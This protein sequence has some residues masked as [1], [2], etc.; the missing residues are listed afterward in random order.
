MNRILKTL[1]LAALVSFPAAAGPAAYDVTLTSVTPTPALM[2][3]PSGDGLLCPVTISVTNG[4]SRKIKTWWSYDGG[5]HRTNVTL[6]PGENVI[7]GG[8]PEIMAGTDAVIT[9][10]TGASATVAI[11]EPEKM[12]IYLVQHVHT[13]IGYTK[14]QT[15]ILTEHLR[16]ID[17]ALDYCDATASYPD[18]ARFRWTC[19]AS[20]AVD[21]WLRGRPKEQVERFLDYI[22]QGLIEVTAMYF[23]MSELS[24]E[25][26]YRTFLEPLKRF[27]EL[28]IPVKTAM[29]DDVNGV[30]WCLADLLP[31]VGVEYL[32]MG[33][34]ATRSV[35]P[36]D[37]PTVYRWE[38]PSGRSL[39]SYR[40][41]HYNTGNF[42]GIEKGDAGKFEA[43]VFS[44]LKKLRDYGYPYPYVSVQYSGFFTDNSPPNPA[45]CDIIRD[46]NEK[47]VW[48]RLRSATISEFVSR[49]DKEFGETLPVYRDAFPD[50]WTDGFG[51]AAR[52]SAASRKTQSDAAVVEGLLSMALLEGDSEAA[53]YG[54]VLRK[55][56]ENLL[57]YDEHTF[58]SSESIS[59]PACENSEVQWA[60]KGS[61][62]W[63][64]L[65][66][67]QMMYETA[68]GRLQGGL[69]RSDCPTV[70]FF[71]T[72][73]GSRSSL[74]SIFI[75]NSLVPPGAPFEIVDADGNILAVQQE[76]I[77]REGRYFTVWAE[78][79]PAMGY[80]T[81]EIRLGGSSSHIP[82]RSGWDGQ[83]L[84]NDHYRLVLDPVKGGISSVFDKELG[85]E[86]LDTGAPWNLGE[87]IYETL[88]GDRGQMNKLR[89][90]K[91]DRKGFESVKFT[92]IT[93]GDLFTTVS[94]EGVL[95]GCDRDF[96]V[97]VD[98][99]LNNRVKRID[100]SYRLKR[101]PETDP[102]GIYVAF[103]F[104]VEGG[105]LAFDVPGGLLVAGENQIP[106]T[107][108][109]WNTVQ[110]FV[111]ARNQ[112]MQ[113]LVS[114]GEVPLYMMGELMNDPFRKEHIHEKTHFFS[115]VMNNYWFT[116]FRAFQEGEFRWNYAITS[117]PGCSE[118]EAWKFGQGNRTPVYARVQPG[119]SLKNGAKERA[120]ERSLLGI[121]G[122][123]LLLV[124]TVPMPDGN[125]LVNV[126]ETSGRPSTL[127]LHDSDGNRLSFVQVNVLDE[128]TGRR[129]DSLGIPPYG[130]V[131]VRVKP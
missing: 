14:P 20:W 87:P 7:S 85:K 98:V 43:G 1:I 74:C 117:L 25:G 15:E 115:W 112:E 102:S 114:T 3:A 126:R 127:S 31:E 58:G 54:P 120:R 69:Y 12:T 13:D 37:I 5:V 89:F 11:P 111:S 2:R 50:Y 79:I 100:L 61:Y 125:L 90:D 21:E 52:E 71:N 128:E 118:P 97:K 48:P 9:L 121:E 84:E 80:K 105:K 49:V 103:P 107:V 55:I 78:D 17:Y 6:L 59:D 57:F 88:Q 109:A 73:G 44:Y 62:V 38:S 91:Y 24:G 66:N 96:G 32:T 93:S 60:E 67:T 8:V 22:K 30:A 92:G 40:S 131:F 27:R 76:S 124:G 101:L 82:E 23:N 130:N 70:T 39:I 75:D 77:R 64:A 53:G 56:R 86:L 29:Q 129:T 68:A 10:G 104:G 47:Y 33:A 106:G 119:T 19:E 83:V 94:F 95:E 16:Y 35:I 4:S 26:N 99:K 108:A 110:S 36:F 34:N 46:W 123:N 45:E 42:W 18:D 41:D 51:S 72:L 122:E 63:D 81:F 65:K 116:N 28:G 113:V